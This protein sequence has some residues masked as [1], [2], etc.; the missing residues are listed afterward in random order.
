MNVVPF[1]CCLRTHALATKLHFFAP[2]A[3][4]A[5]VTNLRSFAEPRSEEIPFY[6][7]SQNCEKLLVA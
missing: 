7:R 6:A 1:F 5:P 3:Y 2:I 4:T